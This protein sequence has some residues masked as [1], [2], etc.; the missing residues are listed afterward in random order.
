VG[1]RLFENFL[2]VQNR[3]RKCLEIRAHSDLGT[4]TDLDPC[5]TYLFHVVN[6]RP[7]I[8]GTTARRDPIIVDWSI[9]Y[10]S[11]RLILRIM[12]HSLFTS[13]EILEWKI[14]Q[15]NIFDCENTYNKR[16]LER[17]FS[18]TVNV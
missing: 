13:D 17:I 8:A 10:V 12:H 18:L 5:G 16:R 6:T 7:P 2:N 9:Q 4:G 15:I 11:A 14:P 1:P 3:A